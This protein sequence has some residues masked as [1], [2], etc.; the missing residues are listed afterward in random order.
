MVEEEKHVKY[1]VE[2]NNYVDKEDKEKVKSEKNQREDTKKADNEEEKHITNF[3]TRGT[4]VWRC[5][6]RRMDT[7]R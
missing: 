3:G 7:D 4:T 1:I 6:D 2:E 5:S